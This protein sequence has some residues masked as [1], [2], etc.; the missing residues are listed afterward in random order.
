ML[1]LAA[2][3][4]G[5]LMLLAL[6]T[7]AKGAPAPRALGKMLDENS[8]KP[9]A[10]KVPASV[11]DVVIRQVKGAKKPTKTELELAAS[12]AT[13]AGY[14]RLG[15]ALLERAKT[16]PDTQKFH[17]LQSP[18]P[19][20]SGD[21]WNKF[22]KLMATGKPED[23]DKGRYGIFGMGTRRLVD[24]GLMSMPEKQA[25]GSW[26]GTWVMKPERFAA[27]PLQYK[28]F[29]RSMAGFHRQILDRYRDAVRTKLDGV[30][31][32]M[33]G[34]L[35][36]AHFAGIEGLGKWLASPKMREKFKATSAAYQ[37]TNGIF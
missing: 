4:G 18:L 25:D 6:I 23:A 22:V 35:A 15:D 11:K 30:P 10:N 16:A 21:A 5:L 33:S 36:V 13:V 14:A 19:E 31:A 27:P 20:V 8:P 37:K 34:L 28:V 3:F 12:S 29:E 32:T 7:K 26:R 9:Y 1:G 17:N 24:F 2:G